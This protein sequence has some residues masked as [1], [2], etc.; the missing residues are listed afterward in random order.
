LSFRRQ[1]ANPRLSRGEAL[2]ESM[3]A[4]LDTKGFTDKNRK[5]L[6][7]YAHPWF[8]APYTIVGDGGM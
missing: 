4:L 2:R 6:F 3:V 5:M 8:W 1:T 7:A